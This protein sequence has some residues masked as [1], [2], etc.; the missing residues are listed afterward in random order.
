MAENC[1]H[2]LASIADA[3]TDADAVGV[4]V[5]SFAVVMHCIA[6]TSSVNEHH[7]NGCHVTIISNKNQ[8]I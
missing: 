4:G 8:Q 6:M 7:Y 3:D 1:H 5:D 2:F